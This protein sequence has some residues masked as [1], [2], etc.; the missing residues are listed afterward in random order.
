MFLD[1]CAIEYY[2][3]TNIAISYEI[4]I[5]IHQKLY[6]DIIKFGFIIA[7]TLIYLWIDICPKAMI[8]Q[9]F[10]TIAKV[11]VKYVL[12]VWLYLSFTNQLLLINSVVN[13]YSSCWISYFIE[14]IY[15]LRLFLSLGYC[16]II[17]SSF[18][19]T[20]AYIKQVILHTTVFP[21]WSLGNKQVKTLPKIMFKMFGCRQVCSMNSLLV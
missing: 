17:A 20:F 8:Q 19:F 4:F 11:C 9:T 2:N 15:I 18:H 7:F 10:G 16:F 13:I 5:F 3:Y 21:S 6:I 1:L 14:D 12:N